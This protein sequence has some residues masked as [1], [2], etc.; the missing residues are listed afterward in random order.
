MELTFTVPRPSSVKNRRVLTM[1]DGKPRSFPSSKAQK[2]TKAIRSAAAFACNEFRKRLPL[3]GDDDVGIEV[4]HNVADDTCEVR[5]WSMGPRPKGKTGRKSDLHGLI[6][7]LAD[8][9]QGIAMQNDNQV[10]EVRMR[11]VL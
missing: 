9:L 8:A 10:V 6:E 2:D 7:L 4:T 3:F 1:I 5:V 11:R